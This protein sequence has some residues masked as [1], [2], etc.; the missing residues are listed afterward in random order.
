[1]HPSS[2]TYFIVEEI[3][4]HKP[5]TNTWVCG[6]I[7]PK[8]ACIEMAMRDHLGLSKPDEEPAGGGLDFRRSWVI[9]DG[10]CTTGTRVLD[11]LEEFTPTDVYI[12]GVN[13]IDASGTVGVLFGAPVGSGSIG[14]WAAASRKKGF[15]IIFPVGLEKLV[16]GSI[17]KA[18]KEAGKT[19]F[20]YGMGMNCGLLPLKGGIT[21]TELEAIEIL[22]GAT[23]T[24]ISAGG[25][26]GAE[27]AIT[28]VIKGEDDQVKKAIEYVEQSKGAILPDLRIPNCHDCTFSTCHFS[29]GDKAWVTV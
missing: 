27:G 19:K 11:L 28:A 2:S 15:K 5:T 14:R 1:M 29:V 7:A 24:V 18:A 4:G 26:G 8:G 12:K 6:V 3:T 9:K 23:A 21:I 13:G 16:P 22:S 25:L 10:K 20:S 17:E